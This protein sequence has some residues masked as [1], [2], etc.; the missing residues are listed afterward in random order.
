M[1]KHKNYGPIIPGQAVIQTAKEKKSKVVE[2]TLSTGVR[3]RIKTVAASLI[4]RVTSRLVEPEVPM[5]RNPDK[6]RDEPNPLS[7]KYEA[8]VKAFNKARG[9]AAIEAMVMF[10]VELIDPIPEDNKWLEQLQFLAKQDRIDLSKYDLQ[11]P[12]DREYLYK[13]FIAVGTQDLQL[14]MASAGIP[15]EA[16]NR[17][18]ESFQREDEGK[19]DTGDKTP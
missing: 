1:G 6:D 2:V 7:P 5:E 15:T 18:A 11:N 3:A 14:I 13:I 12:I 10:G 9:E 8:D 4:D 17:A 19:S 16:M